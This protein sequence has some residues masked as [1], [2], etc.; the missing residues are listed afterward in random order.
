MPLIPNQ[1]PQLFVS[2]WLNTPEPI[3]LAD[4]RGKVVAIFAFQ[5]LCPGCVAHSLPQAVK[6]R[7]TFPSSDV[8]VL[9]LHTVFEH[10]QAMNPAALHAFVHEYRLCFPIAIDAPSSDP[11][12]NPIPQTMADWQLQ[13]TPS[14]ILLNKQGGVHLSHFGSIS[15][16]ALGALIGRLLAQD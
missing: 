7:D 4:L 1:A 16:L 5:M 2:Q 3:D 11:E 15:D 13:G 12:Q 14:L 8:A 6:L 9:G 10:H